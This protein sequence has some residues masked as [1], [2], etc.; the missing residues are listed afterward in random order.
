MR[1]RRGPAR[2]IELT[3]R[4]GRNWAASRVVV[5]ILRAESRAAQALERA[6]APADLTLPQFNVLMVVAAAPNA[7]LAMFELAQQL[8]TSPPNLTWL[9]N[10]MEERGLIAKGRDEG[11]RRVVMVEL[12][13]AGWRLLEDAAPLVFERER[14]LL[15]GFSAAE[16]RSAGDLLQRF[17]GEEAHPPR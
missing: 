10:R 2:F 9:T 12:T 14:E 3:S 17:L 15:R 5:S 7:R 16:L 6:L 4:S 11:D 13:A 1:G 8:V